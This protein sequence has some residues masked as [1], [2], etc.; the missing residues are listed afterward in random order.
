MLR[1]TNTTMCETTFYTTHGNIV[2][3]H[4]FLLTSFKMDTQ[5]Q[6]YII[7][8]HAITMHKYTLT[9]ACKLTKPGGTWVILHVCLYSSNFGHSARSGST[10]YVFSE[11]V[12]AAFNALCIFQYVGRSMKLTALPHSSYISGI[13]HWLITYE[14]SHIHVMGF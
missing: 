14:L 11:P 8:I 12:C 13:T 5:K 2:L 6:R 1:L 10:A 4:Q 9:I 7:C 3:H